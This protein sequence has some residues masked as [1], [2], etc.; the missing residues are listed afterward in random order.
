MDTPFDKLSPEDG[1]YVF[2]HDLGS[3][4]ITLQAGLRQEGVLQRGR[5]LPRQVWAVPTPNEI[6]RGRRARLEL[7][8]AAICRFLNTGGDWQDLYDLATN[9]QLFTQGASLTFPGWHYFGSHVDTEGH[10]THHFVK[11]GTDQVVRWVEGPTGFIDH[12]TLADLQ[13]EDE[14][15]GEEGNPAAGPEDHPE[16]RRLGGPDDEATAGDAGEPSP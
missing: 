1:F 9:L 10:Y 4:E 13:R 7:L 16:L 12:M 11:D 15:Y 14:D 2:P 6:D 8:G 3:I 5:F